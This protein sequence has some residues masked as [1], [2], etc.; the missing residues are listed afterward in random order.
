MVTCLLF[1]EVTQPWKV[2]YTSCSVTE[3]EKY[4]LGSIY[5]I[6][7]TLQLIIQLTKQGEEMKMSI[8]F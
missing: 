5:Q 6:W 1:P 8:F 3:E 7:L 2:H 4:N